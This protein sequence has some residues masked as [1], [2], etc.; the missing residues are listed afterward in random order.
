MRWLSSLIFSLAF[1]ASLAARFFHLFDRPVKEQVFLLVVPAVGFGILIHQVFPRFAGLYAKVSRRVPLFAQAL[2]AALLFALLSPMPTLIHLADFL[3]AT[4]LSLALLLPTFPGYEYIADQKSRI[5]LWIGWMGGLITSVF[6][7]GFL[8]HLYP[9]WAFP[10]LTVLL[11]TV[12]GIGFYSL[13]RYIQDLLTSRL[14]ASILGLLTVILAFIFALSLILLC[15]RYPPLLDRNLFLASASTLPVFWSLAAL[16]PAFIAWTLR[17]F[18]QR[19]WLARWQ[20]TAI[21]AFVTEN[22]PGI[23]LSLAFFP[24]YI[25]L[26]F[27]FNHPNMDTT[28]NYF[29]ADNFA[30][31]GR[32]AAAKGTGIEMRAVHPFAF[33]VFRPVIWF[34]S[35]FL[36]GDRFAVTLLLVPLMGALC[37]LLAWLFVKKWTGSRTYALLFAG[38]LGVSTTHLLFGSI[39]ETYIFSAAVLLLFFLLLLDEK[40]FLFALVAV[41]VL[42]FGITITNF[43]QTFIGFVVARPKLKP[44]FMY[45]LL[46]S[47]FAITLTTLH[48]AVYPS[49][50]MFFDPAGAGVE[51]EYS[52]AVIGQPA[53][54]LVGRAMLLVRN[55]F[56]YSLVAPH[57]FI[58]TREVG[59]VFPRFNFFK[60]SP[61][62]FSYSG[63]DGLGKVVITIW[64]LLLLAAAL[65]FLWNIIRRRKADL[66]LAFPLVLLFNFA[67]HM[68]YGSEPFLY[69]ADWTYALVLFVAVSLAGAAKRRWFQIILLVFLGLL[70]V[71]QWGFM[72]LILKT[73]FPF[74]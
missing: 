56:L 38:L 35:L 47:A 14:P 7:T 71:N 67:L 12:F 1:A 41:G 57:P 5:A 53:W 40:T 60:L 11:Q 69:A 19:G 50:L 52:I 10:F 32:L 20:E 48:A 68:G 58:Q 23:L 9:A 15:L 31:M 37:I 62:N 28:E 4:G 73:I 61:G 72:A 59:G 3:S 24:A 70:M 2:L 43:I 74:F 18:D 63:Y 17:A 26:S 66:S 29:A 8:S 21:H 55:I 46:A 51:S 49:A 39:V 36:N 16:A 33:F 54:R 27:V 44:I 13:V 25:A 6:V 65:A 30:W 34:L 22:L 42:T 64:M 45:G